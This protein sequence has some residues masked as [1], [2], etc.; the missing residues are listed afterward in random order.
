MQELVVEFYTQ[1]ELLMTGRISL[2]KTHDSSRVK[3]EPKNIDLLLISKHMS[4]NIH[5][6]WFVKN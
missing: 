3:K 6:Y 4:L 5:T 1:K 2:N